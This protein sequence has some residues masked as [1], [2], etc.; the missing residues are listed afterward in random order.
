MKKSNFFISFV[1][2]SILSFVSLNAQE[3]LISPELVIRTQDGN[4]NYTFEMTS[5]SSVVWEAKRSGDDSL[6][7]TTATKYVNPGDI[8][9][10]G[11][12]SEAN[13][14][15]NSDTYPS[16]DPRWGPL[17]GR[18]DYN[19]HVAGTN[20]NLT[21]NC[22]G[23]E[24]DNDIVVTYDCNDHEFLVDGNVVTSIDLYTNSTKWLQP[25]K[26]RNFRCTNPSSTG[27][28]DFEWDPPSHPTG[29][30]TFYYNIYRSINGGAFY[31]VASGITSV[32]WT[33][34]SITLNS[35][36]DRIWYYAK[37]YIDHS[38]E[39]T[40]SSIAKIKGYLSKR[41]AEEPDSNNQNAEKK[42][43][44]INFYTYPNPFNPSTTISYYIPDD[45]FVHLSIFNISGQQITELVNGQKQA[46]EHAV[47]FN[48]NALSGGIYFVRFHIGDQLLTKKIL[49]FK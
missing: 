14:G 25:T 31:C 37:A 23:V 12:G 38:P 33:D 44:E 4:G 7:I 47:N 39:S 9:I 19:I 21:V 22:Y 46:G 43:T 1:T 5:T 16:E 17:L 24:F 35:N 13:K 36:G 2:L 8:T 27:H 40:Q 18:G 6:Y 3:R 15:W 28:P 26:P 42:R 48:A 45:E 30:A 10:P 49:L 11:D 20:D 34:L 41:L 32:S 29:G